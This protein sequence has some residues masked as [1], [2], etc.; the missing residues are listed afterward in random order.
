MVQGSVLSILLLV[1]ENEVL[2][3]N[4]FGVRSRIFPQVEW[5]PS[6]CAVVQVVEE[7]IAHEDDC[8]RIFPYFPELA[9]VSS[10]LLMSWNGDLPLPKGELALTVNH[11]VQDNIE[12]VFFL[13]LIFADID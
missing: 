12:E 7:D 2:Q 4:D 13:F 3:E 5:Q 11:I 8:Q 6:R 1:E 9:V 10:K